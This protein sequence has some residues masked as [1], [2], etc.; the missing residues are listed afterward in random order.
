MVKF[1]F[2]LLFHVVCHVQMPRPNAVA[3]LFGTVS[4]TPLSDKRIG[5]HRQEQSNTGGK[6]FQAEVA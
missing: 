6:P 2:V 4:S 5:G 1:V 3:G